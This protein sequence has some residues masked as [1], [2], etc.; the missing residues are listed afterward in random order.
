MTIGPKAESKEILQRIQGYLPKA[1]LKTDHAP[2]ASEIAIAI[3][4]ETDTTSK[5]PDMFSE[6]SGDKEELSIKTIGLSL[7]TMD[8]VFVK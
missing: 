2:N 7:T 1:F 4:C 3:P 5:F 6:L 8:E